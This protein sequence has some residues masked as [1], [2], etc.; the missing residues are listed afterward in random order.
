MTR[1]SLIVLVL[2]E[3]KGRG[4][5]PICGALMLRCAARALRSRHLGQPPPPF[6]TH[7]NTPH[8]STPTPS[9]W[10]N[11]LLAKKAASGS[12]SAADSGMCGHFYVCACVLPAVHNASM[13]SRD[14]SAKFS[15][16]WVVLS[17]QLIQR[18]TLDVKLGFLFFSV[19]IKGEEQPAPCK[20]QCL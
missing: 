10:N 5:G 20:A 2:Q 16:D 1:S 6:E 14:V 3:L 18:W 13:H 11:F 12:V 9:G 19:T 15:H 8:P 4:Q 17:N 7:T